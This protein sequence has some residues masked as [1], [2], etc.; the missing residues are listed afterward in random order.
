MLL[1]QK[2][3]W[4]RVLS[5]ERHW[6]LSDAV[7]HMELVICLWSSKYNGSFSCYYFWNL[8]WFLTWRCHTTGSEEIAIAATGRSV[9]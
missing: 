6:E 3:L 9:M 4:F 8:V 5:F 1:S 2:I 7:N